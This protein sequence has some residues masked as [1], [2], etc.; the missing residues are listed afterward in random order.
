[1]EVKRDAERPVSQTQSPEEVRYRHTA[2]AVLRIYRGE[3]IQ[4]FYRGLIPSLVG[5]S[6][7]AVQFPLY[8]E[9]KLSLGMYAPE[10]HG[11]IL[12]TGWVSWYGSQRNAR[13]SKY[14]NSRPSPSLSA[15]QYPK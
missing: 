10:Y 15:L 3:G 7:V 13:T 2:D 1:M 4:A 8:E 14:P 11:Q 9:L 6:H 12:T 5:V